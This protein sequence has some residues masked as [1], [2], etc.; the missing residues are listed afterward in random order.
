MG[1]CGIH[2]SILL[3]FNTTWAI[4]HVSSPERQDFLCFSFCPITMFLSTFSHI[5]FLFLSPQIQSFPQ[6]WT[7]VV[8]YLW[9]LAVVSE[10]AGG[11]PQHQGFSGLSHSAVQGMT[12][13]IVRGRRDLA[14]CSVECGAVMAEMARRAHFTPPSEWLQISC[15]ALLIGNTFETSF[16]DHTYAVQKKRKNKKQQ[17]W[18]PNYE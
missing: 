3:T 8:F 1:T 13:A 11:R 6:W 9:I 12:T 16:H 5:Y 15:T 2:Q 4:L 17:E 10:L 7:Q 18:G 14:L